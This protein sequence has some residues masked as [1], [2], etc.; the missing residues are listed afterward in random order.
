GDSAEGHKDDA[1]FTFS[2]ESIGSS[3]DLGNSQSSILLDVSG[4]IVSKELSMSFQYSAENYAEETIEKLINSYK[5]HLTALITNVSEIKKSYLTPSDLT[6]KKLSFKELMLIN[7]ANNIEDI[8]VLSPLQQGLYYHWLLDHSSP[9]YFEQMA[10]TVNSQELSVKLVQQAFNELI[11]RY[12]VLRTAFSSSFGSEPLQIVYKTVEGNF[13]YEKIT[14]NDEQTINE[15]IEK[16][17]EAD[18]IKGFDFEKPSLMRLKVIEVKKGRYVFVWSHHHILMDGWCISILINDFTA[19]LKAISTNQK[20]DLPTPVKYAEYINWLSKVD[21]DLSLSYWKDHLKGLETVIDIPFKDKREKATD[22]KA[23]EET[24]LIDGD[25]FIKLSNLCQELSITPNVFMQG[26][27]GYLLSRYNNTQDV[28]FGSVVSGRP[29]ELTGVE[30]MVGLFIN[31][32]PVRLQYTNDD[33]PKSLLKR[34]QAEAIE[35]TLHHYMNLSEVQS[36]SELG[37]DLL[38]T[39]MV[40]ENYFVHEDTSEDNIQNTQKIVLE[41]VNVFEQT[42]YDFHITISTSLSSLEVEFKYNSEVFDQDLIKNLVSHFFNITEQFSAEKEVLLTQIEY[43]TLKE[44]EQLLVDFNASEVDYPKEK[45]IL[46]LFKEQIKKTPNNIAVVFEDKKITYKELD[47]LSSQLCYTL[48]EDYKIEKGDMIGVLLNRSELSIISIL[49]ILKSGAVYIPIDSELPDNRKAFIIEDTAL[50]LLITETFFILDVD[51][52]EGDVFCVDVEFESTDKDLTVDKINLTLNDLAYIIYTSGSTGNPKGVMIEHSSLTNYLTWAKEYYLSEN[53]I[54]NNFGLFTSLSFD[55]TITSLFLPLISGGALNIYPSTTQVQNL[56]ENYINNDLSCIKL[57]P[58]HISVLGTLGVKSDK[59]EVA[60]VGGEE[61]RKEHIEILRNINPS[62]RIYNEYGPTE[63]T[64]GCVIEEIKSIG[65]KILIGRPIWNTSIYILNEF[66]KIQPQGIL[67]EIYIGGS[68]L[69]RG[70]LNRLDLTSEKFI[71]N[72]FKEGELIY[73]TGD[74]GRWLTDGTI[75]YKG[76]KD[77][78]VK[79]RGYRI[80]LGEIES[81]LLLLN[82]V[83]EALVIVDENEGDKFLVAYYVAAVTLDKKEIKSTLSKVLVEYMLPNYYVQL[84][85]IPLTTNGK[86]D[87]KSLPRVNVNDLIKEEYVAPVT[88]EEILLVSIWS[89]V[90][91]YDKISIKDSFY[92]LGGDSIKI[93]RVISL[94]KQ[95]GYTLKVE[96]ILSNPIIEDLAKLVENNTVFVDQ[97]EAVGEVAITPIQYNFFENDAIFNKSHY[98]QSIVLR[99]RLVIDSLILEQSISSLVLHHDALRMVYKQENNRWLQYNEDSLNKHYKINFYD[100]QKES[101][102]LEALHRIGDELQSSFD[103][104]SG[105]LFQIG[106]FR[107]SDGD[108]LVLIIHHLVVDGVSW[109]IL[110]EDLSNI[111]QAYKSG[112]DLKLPLKTDS[113][114]RWSHLQKDFA[115]S[116][117]MQSERHYWERISKESIPLLP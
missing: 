42:N 26:V 92:N 97:S 2:S 88:N 62:I 98:N 12:S 79:I 29:G 61:L 35:S 6:Y 104:S 48:I 17:K 14:A 54:N 78:Q 27:W 60:I 102:E 34:L 4:M 105:V 75:D 37:Q 28:I 21:K 64:V 76:R 114:L 20:I 96:Q 40:F 83:S 53:L 63:A 87:R 44:R 95:K 13:S 111:Y 24:L 70:Y 89:E 10:Y 55:L 7:K 113:F 106:H 117:E 73:K 59:L 41:E 107:L 74:L 5:H 32:I 115:K 71:P 1:L 69:A 15:D 25:V 86:A 100:L 82:Q 93:I 8:Y 77:D 65:D 11:S 112:S 30:D 43:L 22:F 108:C 99:S 49:G 18:K 52:Y 57:T 39:I 91:N 58:S 80:E 94:L 103:I 66:N 50:K 84:D 85:A 31:T 47:N 23:S 101:K 9:M 33:T 68:G 45:T 36:Q 109:R 67:G 3:I 90:L 72:P 51:F 46:D 19:I 110:L 116:E 81:Q 38:N 16:I 56:L